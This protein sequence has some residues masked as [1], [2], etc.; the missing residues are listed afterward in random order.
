MRYFVTIIFLHFSACECDAQIAISTANLDIPDY[1]EKLLN[2]V[3]TQI[4]D[5]RTVDEFKQ[6]EYWLRP[7]DPKP[8][9]VTRRTALHGKDL[10]VSRFA[11]LPPAGNG[12]TLSVQLL[13]PDAYYYLYRKSE[14][15]KYTL[16]GHGTAWK[17]SDGYENSVLSYAVSLQLFQPKK[18]KHVLETT[19]D[20]HDGIPTKRITIQTNYGAKITAHI[21]RKTYQHVYSEIDKILDVK[22]RTYTE[23]KHV[24]KTEYRTEGGRLW[25]TRHE[26]YYVKSNGKKYP[27]TETTFLEYAPYIPKPDELDIEKQFGIK[28]IPH[29]PRPASAVVKKSSVRPAYWWYLAGGV[30]LA[31]T[32]GLV[33]FA[34]KRRA[35]A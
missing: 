1:N 13:S 6:W 15:G 18:V 12:K 22:A 10:W 24:N 34:R 2:I 17:D 20:V 21:D 27:I 31:V 8:V 4:V 3:N 33:L 26:E 19:N 5:Y 11:I 32:V 35:T 14:E 7:D 28:P 23:G 30:F 9:G 16:T 25:P 29:E